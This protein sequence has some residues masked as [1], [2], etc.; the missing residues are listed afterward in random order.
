MTNYCESKCLS[1]G[2]LSS[3]V[4]TIAIPTYKR[5]KLL[6]QAL[7]SAI[8]QK[9]NHE[10]EIIVVDN[11]SESVLTLLDDPAVSELLRR[12]DVWYYKNSKNVGM[13]GNWNRCIE[14]SRGSYLTIL[15][16]DDAL[17]EEFL[18]VACRQLVLDSCAIAVAVNHTIVF[19]ETLDRLRPTKV[20]R[21]LEAMG[22]SN[23]APLRLSSFLVN[24]RIHGSLGVLIKRSALVEFGGFDPSY[25]PIADYE[26]WVRL[27]EAGHRIYWLEHS[28]C[29][30]RIFA[31]A[32]LAKGMS[33]K[34]IYGEHK[35]RVKIINKTCKQ[36]YA[37]FLSAAS[38]ILASLLHLSQFLSSRKSMFRLL[39]VLPR[40]LCFGLA[41]LF[42]LIFDLSVSLGSGE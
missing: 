17:C 2:A 7:E 25:Y 30:Y 20:A 5:P 40:S 26:L 13:F 8:A 18:A 34:F 3:P 38:L 14:L 19:G 11:D 33:R 31:N 41:F 28:Y 37:A 32:S 24:H 36:P 42:I 6:R 22:H 16:D 23:A 9:F 10:Y 15:N 21:F 27:L 29:F 4:V 1:I 35:I 39:F 12:P